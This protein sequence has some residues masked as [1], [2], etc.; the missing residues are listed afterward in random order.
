MIIIPTTHAEHI[1]KKLTKKP[2][3]EVVFLGKNKDNKRYFPDGEIYVRI[4]EINDLGGRTVV[5]HAGSPD[6]GNGFVELKM[7]LE[8]LKNSRVAPLEVFFTYFPF[9]MQDHFDRLGETNMAENIVK[10]LIDYYKVL[11]TILNL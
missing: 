5:I 1:G 3:L 7:T 10:E 9:G 8:I 6:P 2:D 4:P 11:C